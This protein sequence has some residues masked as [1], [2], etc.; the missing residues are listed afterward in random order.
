MRSGENAAMPQSAWPVLHPTLKPTQNLASG[1]PV[2]RL[3]SDIRR[4]MKLD[5]IAAALKIPFNLC[6]GETG[7]AK[8]G[9]P[10]IL[11][12]DHARTRMVSPER[13]TQCATMITRQ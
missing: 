5:V 3:T 8:G 6:I 9:E 11:I 12:P 2:C 7:P 13:S 10:G 1:K 4:T